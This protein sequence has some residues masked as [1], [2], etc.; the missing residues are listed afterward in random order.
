MGN[1]LDKFEMLGYQDWLPLLRERFDAEELPEGYNAYV[2]DDAVA[3]DSFNDESES[4]NSTQSDSAED[5][6]DSWFW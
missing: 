5:K 1:I 4:N 2:G 3:D 6:N